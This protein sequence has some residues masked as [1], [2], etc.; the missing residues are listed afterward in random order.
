LPWAGLL[1]PPGGERH[2]DGN[3]SRA[4]ELVFV[5]L[6]LAVSVGAAARAADEDDP[7]DV[8]VRKRYVL[9]EQ[10]FD[11]LLNRNAIT[12]EAING[13]LRVSISQSS[14]NRLDSVL[15]NEIEVIDRECS[16]TET[17]KKKLQLAGNEDI[18]RLLN[19]VAELR[20]KYVGV[21]ISMQ[22]YSE[23]MNELQ[24]L[25]GIA[26]L[27]IIHEASLFQKTL[28]R[29]LNDEQRARHQIIERKR[30]VSVVEA[31][32]AIC[33]RAS[34]GIKLT[35]ETRQKFIDTLVTQGQIPPS[36]NSYEPYVA[37]V[38]IG[39]LEN[40]LAPLLTETE[41]QSINAQVAK[42]RQME[43]MLRKSGPW[44]V[45]PKDDED[46]PTGTTKNDVSPGDK[47]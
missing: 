31:A 37:L 7:K 14:Q 29:T 12:I 45:P 6:A 23:V 16:L 2:L 28:R 30:K 22:Q 20:M 46:L 17:Q 13:E 11:Q 41:R 32:L 1:L 36:L 24:M 15:K 4:W 18:V 34:N 27:G 19:R 8:V 5:L 10:Q 33:D 21:S 39:R 9:S 35:G 25:S 44:P 40:L 47:P 38:E 26:Q 43:P 3:T 42:A